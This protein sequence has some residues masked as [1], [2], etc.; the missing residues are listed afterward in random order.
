[1][2]RIYNHLLV[3]AALAALAGAMADDSARTPAQMLAAQ[4]ASDFVYKAP[5][6][7][8]QVCTGFALS[9]SVLGHGACGALTQR[10]AA[11]AANASLSQP[12]MLEQWAALDG[13]VRR[14]S[15]RP[16]ASGAA[17]ADRMR[18]CGGARASARPTSS[19]ARARCGP[20]TCTSLR[21]AC[22]T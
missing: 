12:R 20:R 14:R 22:C 15:R 7:A 11:Q 18:R 1:M 9:L 3:A 8:A 10:A 19:W 4:S 6:K 16:A 5:V 21:P 13:Q 17:R 2:A